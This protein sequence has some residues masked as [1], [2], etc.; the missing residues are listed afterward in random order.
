MKV[1]HTPTALI[2]RS[3]LLSLALLVASPALAVG[4][5]S[6][7]GAPQPAEA[8]D[9]EA[10]SEDAEAQGSGAASEDAAGGDDAPVLRTVVTATRSP[11]T[12]FDVDRSVTGLDDDALTS[13]QP[14]DGAEAAAQAPGVFLQRTNSGAGAPLIRGFVGP[15]N[16]VLVDGVRHE[17]SVFRTG[18]NQYAALLD[19]LALDSLEV[20]VGPGSVLYGSGAVGG[21]IHYVPLRLPAGAGAFARGQVRAASADLGTEASVVGGGSKGSL[22][23]WAGGAWRSHGDLRVG[24]GDEVPLSGLTHLDWRGRLGYDLGG[25]W[26]LRGTYLAT[27]VEDAGRID[28]L[29][30]GEVR[31]YDN[32]DHLAYLD[33][34]REGTGVL[35]E[36]RFNVS[37]HHITERV[38]RFNCTKDDAGSVVDRARCVALDHD[39]LEKKRINDDTVDALSGFATAH[40]QWFDGLLEA[41]GGLEARTESV[42][43]SREDAKASED[44]EFKAKDRGNF[45]DGSTY[46]AFDAFTYLEGRPFVRAGTA[47]VVLTG[48]GRVNHARASAPDVPGL[49]DVDYEATGAVASAGARVLLANQLNVYGNWSQGFRAPNLQ[50][51]TVLGNTGNDFEVPNDEL[52][53]ER[54]DTVELGLKLHRKEARA[55]VAVWQTEVTDAIVKEDTTWEGQEEIDGTP[56]A[57]RVNAGSATYKGVE[58]WAE[59]GAFA[60]VSLFGRAAVME[61]TVHTVDGED[62]PAR[63]VPPLH[64]TA[65][66]RWSGLDGRLEALAQTRFAAAATRLAPKDETDLRICE[67]PAVPGSVVADC[68]GTP[69]WATADV[70][71]SGRPFE[72]RDLRVDLSLDNLLDANYRLHGSGYDAPGLDVK[73]SVRYEL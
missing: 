55:G 22:S 45:S 51:T 68:E 43:S 37:W 42:A 8:P 64:G 30:R 34:A 23:G 61:G 70:R 63:R 38:D 72:D 24:G 60:G 44:F 39:V 35:R 47:E 31:L 27:R 3:A 48:G 6:E 46:A 21:V 10:A 25:G 7:P 18:P 16:L 17:T 65:G 59:T 1:F 57:H 54:S 36:L 19:P 73:L 13:L 15:Q 28:K 56:V 53:P 62:E 52:G 20:L 69:G 58:A 12:V 4:S 41:T 66:L 11:A 14:L 32:D 49:G 2:R 26:Q 50:E 67:D 5:G 40:A 29:G 33:L 9:P 71:V